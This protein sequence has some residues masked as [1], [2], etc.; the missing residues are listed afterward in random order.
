KVDTLEGLK[1]NVIVGRL[2]PAGTGSVMKRLRGVANSRDKAIQAERA[3][4]QAALEAE[5]AAAA[6]NTDEDETSNA[7]E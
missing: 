1:E 6:A 4:A 7:A 5:Q 2:I 3:A